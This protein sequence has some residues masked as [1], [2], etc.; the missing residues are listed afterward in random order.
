MALTAEQNLILASVLCCLYL[1][2]KRFAPD[3]FKR[4]PQE[5]RLVKAEKASPLAASKPSGP[6]EYRFPKFDIRHD[7]DR[8]ALEATK[9]LPYRPFRWGP[10]YPQHMAIRSLS[11]SANWF[12]TDNLYAHTLA[13]RK[14][15]THDP[16]L[17]SSATLPGFHAHALEALCEIASFL[18]TRDP[19]LFKVKRAKYDPS[20]PE[21]FGDSIVGKEAGA[22]IAV[23]N[24]V[25]GDKFD[26]AEIEARDGK[27]WNPMKYAGMLTQDDLALMVEDSQGH[28][29]LQGGSICTAG[30]WRLQDK[31][32]MTLDEIHFHGAVPNYA[33]KYQKSMNKF[34]T[35]MKEDK[36]VERNNFFFQIDDQLSWSVKTNGTEKIFDQFNKGP[37]AGELEK[38]P[39]A[40]APQDATDVNQVYFRC[41]RQT[42][43]RLPK[44]R[45]IL[46]T[47]RTYLQPCVDLADEPGVP[48]RM[49][50]AIRSFPTEDRGVHWYKATGAFE[51]VLLPYLDAKHDEQVTAGVVQLDEK[52]MTESQYPW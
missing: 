32:G 46:F 23:E 8:Q 34:F 45:S 36:M 28:Y 25:T 47:V 17:M 11:N 48:G 1:A 4:T 9:P 15:R 30:F 51:H 35:N 42:L 33:A 22:V 13:I 50:S 14:S 16:S 27:D 5:D 10:V 26:F 44:H 31:A 19:Q 41:E 3:L 52:G 20:K 37:M 38:T 12:Q 7:Y 24:V 21:T 29:R 43:R 39:G 2:V 40:T 18:A 49:A 6:A